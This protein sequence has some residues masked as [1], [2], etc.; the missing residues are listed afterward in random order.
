VRLHVH[1]NGDIPAGWFVSLDEDSKDVFRRRVRAYLDSLDNKEKKQVTDG[2]DKPSPVETEDA[3][4][5][6][7]IFGNGIHTIN[8]ALDT[9]AKV[10]G[11]D[12]SQG[13]RLELICANFN[14]QFAEDGETGHVMGKN[15]YILNTIEGLVKQLDLKV[16][17][18]SEML[19]GIVAKGVEQ[20][21]AT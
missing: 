4:I 8:L 19:I 14:S 1:F 6:F 15:S 3:F 18:A 11:S 17:D 12:K 16:P 2:E 20:N 13:Y 10:I 21:A 9:M 5:T 7:K